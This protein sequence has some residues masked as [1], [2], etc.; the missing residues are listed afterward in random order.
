MERHKKPAFGDVGAYARFCCDFASCRGD[1]NRI[2]VFNAVFFGVFE[3]DLH[4]SRGRFLVDGRR[5]SRKRTGM[6]LIQLPAG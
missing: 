2:A 4:I 1:F 3:V 6:V 5:L